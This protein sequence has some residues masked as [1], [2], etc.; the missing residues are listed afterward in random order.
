M[1]DRRARLLAKPG[2]SQAL[3]GPASVLGR[4]IIFP[5][6]PTVQAQTQVAYSKYDLVHTNSQPYAFQS[7]SPPGIQVTAQFIQQTE[8]EAQYLAGVLHFLRVVTKMNFGQ[9]DPEKGTPPPVLN[10]SAYGDQNFKNVPVLV[11]SFTQSYPD[12]VDYIETEIEGKAAQF[13]VTFTIA[14]DLM[15]QYSPSSVR[16]NYSTSA[17]A[18]GTLYSNG[19]I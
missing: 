6:T 13:P 19:F 14:I 2:Y 8:E 7:S 9:G 11:G 15:V 18:N 5:Y 17:F 4:G 10:F 12:D 16:N 3:Q 1:Q